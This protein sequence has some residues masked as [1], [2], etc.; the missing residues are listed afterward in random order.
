MTTTSSPP[1]TPAMLDVADFA[2][3]L[4]CSRLHIY[5]L[6]DS[7]KMPAP[8]KLGALV[9]WERRAL[10]DWIQAGCPPIRRAGR[11]TR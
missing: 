6:S 11:A 1:T 10:L 8:I 7:G 2:E 9:R 5:R 3:L 4:N